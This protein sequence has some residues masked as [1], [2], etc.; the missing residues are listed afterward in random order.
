MEHMAGHGDE[1]HALGHNE[2]TMMMHLMARGGGPFGHDDNGDGFTG[3]RGRPPL[4]R[5]RKFGADELQLVLLILL[6]AQASYGYEL[7]KRLDEK[8]GG[9]YKPSPGVIYPAL[10]WLEDVGYVTVQQEGTRKRYAIA[11][12]GEQ[13]LAD[14]QALSEAMMERLAQF[15]RQMDFVTQ[16]MREERQPFTPTL[17]EAIHTL[18]RELHQHHRSSE[19]V[20]QQVADILEQAVAALKQ[21][22]R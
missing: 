1:N 14:N 6:Q 15:A 22:P 12:Q 5:G 11:S 13:H 16:A 3:H 17:H 9:F 18:R 7:I 20:Q 19:A 2:R 4:L 10:T 21:I 8:S